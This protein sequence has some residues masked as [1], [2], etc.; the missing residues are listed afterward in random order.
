MNAL[1]L[2]L[3]DRCGAD[4]AQQAAA[5]FLAKVHAELQPNGVWLMVAHDDST[6][7]ELDLDCISCKLNNSNPGM[8][9]LNWIKSRPRS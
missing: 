3:W 8:T 4:V 5:A 1:S 9:A 2:Q 6:I 7:G